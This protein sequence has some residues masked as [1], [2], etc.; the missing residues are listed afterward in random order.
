MDQVAERAEG[1]VDVGGRVRPVDLVEVDP[2]GLQPA[3]AVVDL[4]DDPA[5]RVALHVGVVAHASV[6]LGGEN[7]G[8]AA[9]AGQWFGQ[10]TI[11][12]WVKRIE[13]VFSRALFADRS[14][15]LELDVSGLMRGAWNHTDASEMSRFSLH[16]TKQEER[17]A[18]ARLT[19]TEGAAQR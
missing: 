6:E 9:T 19:L 12:P 10:F 17:K 7:D 3:Q 5:P 11:L 18:V 15:R 8:V 14:L 2:V 4:A 1:F 13:A 16:L